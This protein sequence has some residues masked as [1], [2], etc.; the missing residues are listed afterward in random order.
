[1]LPLLGIFGTTSSM[2][3][4]LR[5]DRAFSAGFSALELIIMVAIIL[6]ITAIGMPMFLSYL[7][8]AEADGAAREIV[9]TLNRARQL[10]I[11]QGTS[12]SVETQ[13]APTRQRLCSGT[14]VPC[15]GGTMWT[16]AGTDSSGWINLENNVRIVQ[17][18]TI[19]FGTLGN[20]SASGTIRVRNSSSTACRD[21]IVSPSGRIQ[22]AA[23]C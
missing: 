6:I 16:G 9:T 13:Q 4:R 23:G 21:V 22:M 19:T 5:G 7:R 1:M 2:A 8:T 3:G 10:A 14:T 20:A 18:P 11:T 17:S 15:P 12:Y